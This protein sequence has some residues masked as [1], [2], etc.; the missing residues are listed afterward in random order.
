M[1]SDPPFDMQHLPFGN[2]RIHQR[3]KLPGFRHLPRKVNRQEQGGY[4]S[5]PIE[6]PEDQPT[7]GSSQQDKI[8]LQKKQE[9]ARH[10]VIW[11][12]GMV[13]GIIHAGG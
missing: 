5:R 13:L 4:A 11:T 9:V 2:R 12:G 10:R 1:P 8:R 7:R 6:F 3:P